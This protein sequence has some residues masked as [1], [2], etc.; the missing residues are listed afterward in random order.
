MNLG[1]LGCPS[2]WLVKALSMPGDQPT[3]LI[4]A[5]DGTQVSLAR[6]PEKKSFLKYGRKRTEIWN[7][8][9]GYYK[10]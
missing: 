1:V 4:F 3:S 9:G 8:S 6:V 10:T 7:G 5:A 2:V